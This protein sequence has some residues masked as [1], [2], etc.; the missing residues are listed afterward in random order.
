MNAAVTK[1]GM[2]AAA[3]RAV[4]MS[5]VAANI[6]NVPLKTY[7][8]G[9]SMVKYIRQ[10]WFFLALAL[11][12]PIC[13]AVGEWL[14]REEP[15]SF[16]WGAIGALTLLLAVGV[17]W[18]RRLHRPVWPDARRLW[19]LLGMAALFD[20]LCNIGAF[21]A[22][23]QLP[24]SLSMT[25]GCLC[26]LHAL[27]R[28]WS[29]GIWCAFL[30]L[31]LAQAIGFL[32]YGSRINS[33]VLAETFEASREEALAYLAPGNIVL[34]ALAFVAACGLSFLQH[35]GLRRE[36]RLAL[37][38]AGLLSCGLSL[39]LGGVIP[40]PRQSSD[41]YWPAKEIG[42]LCEA[43]S[44][45]VNSNVATIEV[46][47]A[48]PS[49][50][51]HPSSSRFIK[52]GQK[53]VLVVHVGESVRADRLGINGYERE[54]TPW[55]SSRSDLINF[56]NCISA[57]CDTCQAQIAILTDG[58]RG[59]RETR[60][61]FVPHVGSVLDLFDAQ[62]FGVY[63]FFG[64]RCA[65]QLKYDR[66]VRILTR[67]SRARYNA[68]GSPWTSIPQMSQVLRER[69]G[70]NMLFFVN[71]EGSHTPF[72][73]YDK[74]HPLF[75]PAGDD[76]QN[77]SAHAEAVNNAY[78]NTIAYTDEF[79]RRV[80]RQLEGRPFVYLYISDHGEYLGHDGI[81]GRAALGGS[82][83]RYHDTEGCKVGFFIIAS[84]EFADLHPHCREA[85]RRLREHTGMVVGQEHVFHTLLGLFGIDT[86]HYD[87][88][89]DLCSPEA[90]PY[91][92]PMPPLLRSQEQKSPLSSRRE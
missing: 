75:T 20:G 35:W 2:N 31:E 52:P 5:A 17:L 90:Q 42:A 19:F 38:N 73:H 8:A 66:V 57:A 14:D 45:A 70:D 82:R 25:V 4:A 49:P 23:W 85:L 77:P 44:E 53:V 78:D 59:V 91:D 81:W 54:T 6:K 83:L 9:L 69:G 43:C 79:V 18:A 7:S 76:F 62:G 36:G 55:L 3:A 10:R 41:Y 16:A 22:P 32:Q 88:K 58:R 11:P 37:A 71:N 46:A 67:C 26:L 47:E 68:S 65:Q 34:L 89:L 30:L 48:L 87:P 29:V 86:P 60:A 1:R 27:M 80:V 84:Q 13:S 40:E 24:L 51:A 72:G 56:P 64:R 92:G 74:T 61:D 39:L 50:A 63:S 33:L 21:A 12:F 28:R 15:S